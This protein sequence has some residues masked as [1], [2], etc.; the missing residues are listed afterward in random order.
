MITLALVVL[1]F[2]LL[3]GIFVRSGKSPRD[4]KTGV[5]DPSCRSNID[6]R[7]TVCPRCSRDVDRAAVV[8]QLK[9]GQVRAFIGAGV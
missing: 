3:I 1:F 2:A 6:P 8:Q 5:V 9:R 4:R 7:A